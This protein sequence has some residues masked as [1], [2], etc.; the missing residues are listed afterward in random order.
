MDLQCFYILTCRI[1]NPLIHGAVTALLERRTI[2]T[3]AVSCSL[4]FS[5]SLKSSKNHSKSD[6]FLNSFEHKLSTYMRTDYTLRLVAYALGC[7]ETPQKPA[8]H[9]NVQL[10]MI[11]IMQYPVVQ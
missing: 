9:G 4:T 1:R 10:I 11:C 7:Q 8:L 6:Q 5:L 2:H 3:S